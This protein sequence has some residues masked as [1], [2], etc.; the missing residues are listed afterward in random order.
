MADSWTHTS[1]KDQQP[2]YFSL[3]TSCDTLFMPYWFSVT[4]WW[5]L[6]VSSTICDHTAAWKRKTLYICFRSELYD[7][8]AS[9]AF[10]VIHHETILCCSKL[11]RQNDE[12]LWLRESNTDSIYLQVG[13]IVILTLFFL[14][15]LESSDVFSLLHPC[16]GPGFAGRA[17]KKLPWCRESVGPTSL[18]LVNE[19][20]KCSFA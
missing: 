18:C 2:S 17:S 3:S 14:H 4:H 1:A 16:D 5:R 19:S 12:L 10:I 15:R 6:W 7:E 8:G 9:E 13:Y 20:F 11:R